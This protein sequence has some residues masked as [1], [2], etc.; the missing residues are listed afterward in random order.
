[1]EEKALTFNDALTLFLKTVAGGQSAHTSQTYGQALMYLRRYLEESYQWAET[2]PIANLKP[3][4]LEEF[5]TWLLEQYYRPNSYTASIPLAE[6]TRSLYLTATTRFVRFLVLRK[7]LPAFDFVEYTRLK[8]ELHQATNVKPKPVDQKIPPIE[9]VAALIDAAKQPPHSADNLA[10]GDQRRRQLAWLR[11]LAIILAL[12][13]SGLRVSELTSLKRANLDYGRQG[14]WVEG[15]GRKTRFVAFDD[16]AWEAI[17]VYLKE[18]NDEALP[19]QVE[20]YP[21]FCR[22]DRK[23]KGAARLPLSARAI[24]RLMEQLSEQANLSSRFNLSP[25]SLRHYFANGLLELTG[26]IALVQEALGHQDPKTTRGYTRVKVEQI[27]DGVR[28]LGKQECQER[29]D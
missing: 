4:M 7:S 5:P 2:T 13:S 24:Q 29:G 23:A 8:E 15:K 9:V 18:R 28:A 11:D 26:N 1:M 20:R 14:A 3:S 21:L 16:E 17:Q 19:A 25:H 27:I 12:K 10:P 6:S 22:H